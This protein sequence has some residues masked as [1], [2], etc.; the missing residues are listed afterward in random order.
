MYIFR[1][2]A[3]TENGLEVVKEDRTVL[4]FCFIEFDHRLGKVIDIV[5]KVNFVDI[6][7]PRNSLSATDVAKEA[8]AV[9][10]ERI[11]G[12]KLVSLWPVVQDSGFEAPLERLVVLQL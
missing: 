2:S 8:K 11:G 6:I 12:N 9:V 7:F 3:G 1:V 4:Q 10:E 5:P